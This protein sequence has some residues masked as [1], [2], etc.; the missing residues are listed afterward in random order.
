VEVARKR[1]RVAELAQPVRVLVAERTASTTVEALPC[2]NR[3]RHLG[4][5]T[6]DVEA[7]DLVIVLDARDPQLRQGT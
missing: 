1:L 4:R 5:V 6:V 2:H 3:P 7:S